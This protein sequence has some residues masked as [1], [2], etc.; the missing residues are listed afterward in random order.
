MAKQTENEDAEDL[1]C[2]F[3]GASGALMTPK[4][5]RKFLE[6]MDDLEQND[7]EKF[8]EYTGKTEN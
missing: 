4:D 2:V 7:P 1:K 6:F 3:T 5:G 8:R